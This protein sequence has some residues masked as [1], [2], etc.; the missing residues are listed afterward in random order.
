MS[1]ELIAISAFVVAVKGAFATCFQNIRLN[2]CHT[3]CIDFDCR[4]ENEREFEKELSKLEQKIEKNKTK[5]IKMK[6]RKGS[7]PSTPISEEM[8]ETFL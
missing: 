5:I 4:K 6:E 8:M 3:C 7:E 1:I 2:N